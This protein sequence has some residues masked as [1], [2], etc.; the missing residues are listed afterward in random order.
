M[1]K[2]KRHYSFEPVNEAGKYPIK[3]CNA[4]SIYNAGNTIMTVNKTVPVEPLALFKGDDAH[5][6]I[7]EDFDC[8]LE[9][10][11]GTDTPADF[12]TPT[13]GTFGRF[14]A[15]TNPAGTKEMRAI[16]IKTHLTE[17]A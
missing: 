7:E 5:P 9:F 11:V 13:P 17:I 10:N 12:T 16:I 15:T 4:F 3:G 8:F 6:D 14:G 2:Y 1:A